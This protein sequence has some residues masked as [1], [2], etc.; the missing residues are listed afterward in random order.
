MVRQEGW[1]WVTEST[2]GGPSDKAEM[3]AV[4]WWKKVLA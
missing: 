3:L 1:I 4:E 2:D